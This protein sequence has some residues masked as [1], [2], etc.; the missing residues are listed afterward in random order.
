MHL[1]RLPAA[2][3][4]GLLAGHPSPSQDAPSGPDRTVAGCARANHDR[5]A[6]I[7]ARAVH[8]P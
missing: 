4:F 7:G 5:D 6:H 8:R 2:A 1:T 3:I